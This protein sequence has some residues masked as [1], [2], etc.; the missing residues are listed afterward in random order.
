MLHLLRAV[1]GVRLMRF[2]FGQPLTAPVAAPEASDGV[3]VITDDGYVVVLGL[4]GT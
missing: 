2:D 3:M 1:D 4:P